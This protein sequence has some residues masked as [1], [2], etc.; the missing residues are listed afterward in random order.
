MTTGTAST[1][2]SADGSRVMI[3]IDN[4]AENV[5]RL[6]EDAAA[7]NR[8]LA[9]EYGGH[10]HEALVKEKKTLADIHEVI[11]LWEDAQV[12]TKCIELNHQLINYPC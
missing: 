1:V 5:Q 6:E 9:S 3:T 10:F 4:L 2:S 11:E 12:S 7:V 8:M